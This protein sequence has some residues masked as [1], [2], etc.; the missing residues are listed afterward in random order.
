VLASSSAVRAFAATG[1]AI[2]AVAIGPQTAATARE[3][4]IEVVAEAESSDLDGLVAAVERAL[5]S[6]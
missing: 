6:M 2:P 4:A 1:A 5:A 3:H